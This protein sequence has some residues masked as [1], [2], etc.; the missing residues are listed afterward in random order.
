MDA[1]IKLEDDA[2]VKRMFDFVVMMEH[3]VPDREKMF[4]IFA[5]KPESIMIKPG[6]V[7]VFKKFVQAVK[8]LKN[9]KKKTANLKAKNNN[10]FKAKN[11]KKAQKKN[12]EMPTL[13]YLT[14]QMKNWMKKQS[15]NKP[16]TFQRTENESTFCFICD[17]CKWKVHATAN[18]N[19]KVCLSN[20]HKHFRI[21]ERC[22][23]TNSS[24]T[25][26][27][28]TKTVREFFGSNQPSTSTSRSTLQSKK[29]SKVNIEGPVEFTPEVDLTNDEVVQNNKAGSK[30]LQPPVGLLVDTET[31]GH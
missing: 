23:K 22:K 1:I 31:S 20:I 28:Q 6:L 3:A 15:I 4:G 19:G 8:N 21:S 14:D 26:P 16:F 18:A 10:A 2:E 7:P 12:I 30:N 13:E 17:H 27:A 11:K 5:N 9:P 24:G 29:V 25:I